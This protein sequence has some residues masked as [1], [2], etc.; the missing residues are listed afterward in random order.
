MIGWDRS[1]NETERLIVNPPKPLKA[2]AANNPSGKFC[3][4]I[5]GKTLQVQSCDRVYPCGVCRV[6]NEQNYYLK[7][8]DDSVTGV[9]G[10]FDSEYYFDGYKNEKPLFT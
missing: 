10:D 5:Y 8:L 3:V 9:G 1:Y 2:L 4:F 6:N 7:G